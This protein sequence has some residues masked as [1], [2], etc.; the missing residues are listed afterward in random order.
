MPRRI[1][2]KPSRSFACLREWKWERAPGQTWTR[3]SASLEFCA[4]AVVLHRSTASR[5]RINSL[6]HFLSC[7][8]HAYKCGPLSCS[9]SVVYNLTRVVHSVSIVR[10]LRFQ[11]PLAPHA[12]SD[13]QK[14]SGFVRSDSACKTCC[15]KKRS[16]T[17]PHKSE[18]V[19]VL[20]YLHEDIIVTKVSQVV[21]Q[22]VLS[23][24]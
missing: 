23:K 1:A 14:M 22:I 16:S 5:S 9:M 15:N 8:L 24:F 12:R 4:P 2:V 13:Q 19:S 21:G 18:I 10:L 3:A 11:A 17:C 20:I 7:S 6:Q